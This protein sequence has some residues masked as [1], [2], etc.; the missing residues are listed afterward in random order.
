MFRPGYN[1][2]KDLEEWER[3]KRALA[4]NPESG[5]VDATAPQAQVPPQA[6]GYDPAAG[7]VDANAPPVTGD[8]VADATSM[9][10]PRRVPALS[11]VHVEAPD[12]TEAP[13]PPKAVVKHPVSQVAQNVTAGSVQ[14]TPRKTERRDYGPKPPSRMQTILAQLGQM[15]AQ[16]YGATRSG[17]PAVLAASNARGERAVQIGQ[18]DQN[19]RGRYAWRKGQMQDKERDDARAS[20]RE[21]RLRKRE[22][23]Q[24][25]RQRGLDDE[26]RLKSNPASPKNTKYRMM[27]EA[28][29]PEIVA[30]I[31]KEKWATFTVED[32]E[33]MNLA[34]KKA[35]TTSK[36]TSEETTHQRRRTEE[37]T[38][39]EGKEKIKAKHRR[40]LVS[41]WGFSP[42]GAENDESIMETLAA[43]FGGA[44]K[45]PPALSKRGKLADSLRNPKAR[46]AAREKVLASAQSEHNKTQ[47]E[48]AKNEMADFKEQNAYA[49]AIDG[50]QDLDQTISQ[51]EAQSGVNLDAPNAEK[52]KIAGVGEVEGVIPNWMYNVGS[53]LGIDAAKEGLQNRA[54]LREVVQA[55]VL[56]MS[57]KAATDNER[58]E[59][60]EIYALM[61]TGNEQQM[62]Q[63]LRRLKAVNSRRK[64]DASRNF[65]NAAAAFNQNAANPPS[66]QTP[67]GTP[68]PAQP[69]QAPAGKIRVRLPDG[70]TPLFNGTPEE[71]KAAGYEVL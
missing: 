16:A 61:A 66:V 5:D 45:V 11:P 36:A 9:N 32:G 70:R 68:S 30:R 7:D 44:D 31:P 49:K 53:A 37:M 56:E 15:G 58:K 41:P 40:P 50:V 65:P 48:D 4:Y 67:A 64:D 47:G 71:A 13:P 69:T 8:M 22:D 1:S 6:D 17:H 25:A 28:E 34:L 35:D 59:Y 24:D 38:D 46:Y 23:A 51:F 57:G 43:Q 54:A 12:G 3:H 42:G 18:E 63:G 27:V 21:G 14:A 55:R 39:F 29:Y 2:Q 60:R 33:G 10:D 19:E 26:R 62:I 52:S 20:A